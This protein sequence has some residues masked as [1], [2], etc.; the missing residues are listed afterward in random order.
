MREV[1][2]ALQESNIKAPRSA[3]FQ[4]ALEMPTDKQTLAHNRQTHARKVA[5]FVKNGFRQPLGIDVGVPWL[6][7]HVRHIVQDGNHRL[8]AAIYRAKTLHEDPMLPFIIDGAVE[9]AR[10]LGL[11][12]HP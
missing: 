6:G 8:A 9:Y 10:E 3:R 4:A 5:W 11:W 12:K 1:T 2:A 7:C